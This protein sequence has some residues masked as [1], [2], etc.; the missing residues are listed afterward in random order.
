MSRISEDVAKVRMYLGPGVLYFINLLS[1]FMWV[2]YAMLSVS[3]ILTIYTL[4][5]LPILSVSIYLVSAVINRKS[6]KIQAQL[7]NISHPRATDTW[8]YP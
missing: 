1:L 6:E 7:K 5:P 3:P 4:L 8:I 2:L